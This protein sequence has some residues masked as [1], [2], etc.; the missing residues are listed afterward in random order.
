MQ[1]FLGRL[2][3]AGAF[4]LAGS[5]V[6]AARYLSG[7]LGV[8]T[9]AA[10][11]LFLALLALITVSGHNM[12]RALRSMT[13]RDWMAILFQAACGM[14]LFRMFLLKG[15]SY[16]SAG[17]AGLLTGATPALTALLAVSLLKEPL[18]K[19]RIFGIISTVAGI[20]LIQGVLNGGSVLSKQHLMG[21]LFVLA[22]AMCE[23]L[24]SVLSRFG[25]IRNSLSQND[26][27]NPIVQTT[28]VTGMALALCLG[29]ALMEHPG[30][31]LM[32]LRGLEWLALLWY[33]LFVTA[34]GYI[35]WYAGIKRCDASVAAAFSGMMLVTSLCLSVAL[36]GEHP[37]GQQCLGGAMV[38][39]GMIFSG[40]NPSDRSKRVDHQ[41]AH[42][43]K[44]QTRTI[45][46]L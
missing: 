16:T 20:L 18:Y 15:L 36:L 24:F 19:T 8:F 12:P 43:L 42:A 39:L 45:T 1:S 13:F 21:N 35:L 40:V 6:V 11:S 41:E 31:T 25:S 29:P 10:A 2:Y 23:S 32:T 17:E 7:R 4:I 3:L 14:F 26:E 44:K 5:S 22:A 9:I 30:S 38:V 46:I 37:S 28:L 27:L 34:L 33:G